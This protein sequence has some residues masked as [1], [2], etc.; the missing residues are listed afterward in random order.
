MLVSY[1]AY[2]QKTTEF[3]PS[4]GKAR[5]RCQWGLPSFPPL[6]FCAP[7]RPLSPRWEAIHPWEGDELDSLQSGIEERRNF[8]LTESMIY[9]IVDVGE[10]P[11]G[12]VPFCL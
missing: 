4:S 6:F 7:A 3:K 12:E 1:L 9:E 10:V 11:F 8:I 2:A 5:L